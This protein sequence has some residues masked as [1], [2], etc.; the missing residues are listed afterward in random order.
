MLYA[1][2]V[3]IVENNFKYLISREGNLPDKDSKQG[4]AYRQKTMQ[5]S[6]RLFFS[7][8]YFSCRPLY[9][10]TNSKKGSKN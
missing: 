10:H 8:I 1:L 2:F 9:Y 5:E 4:R 7:E 6:D 3:G